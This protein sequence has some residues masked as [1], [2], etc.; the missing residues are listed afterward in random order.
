MEDKIFDIVTDLFE[1]W[2][3]KLEIMTEQRLKELQEGM[4]NDSLIN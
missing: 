4:S 1:R 3:I 2:H